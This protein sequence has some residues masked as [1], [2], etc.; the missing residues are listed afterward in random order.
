MAS[1]GATAPTELLRA[2]AVLAEPP[3]ASHAAV[4]DA[5]GLGVAPDGAAYADVF[6]FQ[7]HPY[8]SVYLGA[9][10]MLG[11]DVRERVAGF[12]RAVGR[13]PPAEPDHLSALLALYA[14]LLDEAADAVA[15]PEGAL[16]RQSATALVQEHLAP[17]VLTYLDRMAEVTPGCYGVW[18]TLTATVLTQTWGAS[19]LEGLPV[20]L[21]VA[22]PLPDPRVDGGAG[23]AA[24]LLA[25]VRSGMIVTRT[26]LGELGRSLGLGLR[27]GERRFILEHLLAQDAPG[28]L[29][30]LSG[31]AAIAEARHADRRAALGPVADFWAARARTTAVLLDALAREGAA[32][33]EVV[34]AGAS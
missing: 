9:E 10:G 5:L 1:S 16:A 33:L 3:D 22:P 17:W 27:V 25:P 28:V 30:G 8:A 12:W 6:L 4:A 13:T 7:F 2:L 31:L 14:A 20:H 21:L 24:L 34:Q 11:G 19:P 23:F 15:T 18:A 26:D 29:G 32:A